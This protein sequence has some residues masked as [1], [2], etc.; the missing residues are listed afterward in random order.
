MF[1]LLLSFFITYAVRVIFRLLYVFPIDDAIPLDE[2]ALICVA[3]QKIHSREVRSHCECGGELEPLD[4]WKWVETGD[5]RD[6]TGLSDESPSPPTGMEE[7]QQ[8][9]QELKEKE[10]RLQ[11]EKQALKDKWK[12]LR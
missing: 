12:K 4:K 7:A 11:A 2:G 3:C 9:L 5:Q 10:K 1:V 8:R 6:D